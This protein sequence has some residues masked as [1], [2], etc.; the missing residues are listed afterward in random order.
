MF[1][2]NC[3]QQ[4]PD[5]AKFCKNCGKPQGAVSPTKTIQFGHYPNGQSII[6]KI[7]RAQN[8]MLFIIS[9]ENII[10]LPYHQPGGNITWAN[11]TLR[12]WL[13]NDFIH[14]YFTPAEQA[15][16]LPSILNNDNNLQ[17]NTPGGVRTTDKVFLLSNNEANQLFANNQERK[18]DKWWRLRSPGQLPIYATVVDVYG[19]VETVGYGV[20][21]DVGVR[22]AMWIKL[23]T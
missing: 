15:R 7:L 13:N 4:L 21:Y 8:N 18:L 10:N 19:E 3:G 16:I 5:G 2:M 23:G 22:P 14:G 1:C 11:C 20:Q 9:S 6:W 12:K 17:Y